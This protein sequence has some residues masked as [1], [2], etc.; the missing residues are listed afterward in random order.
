MV[1]SCAAFLIRFPDFKH[2]VSG[3]A[4]WLDSYDT[5]KWVATS[6]EELDKLK[7]QQQADTADLPDLGLSPF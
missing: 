4:L 5:P 1:M 2:K 6:I 3:D 7:Q